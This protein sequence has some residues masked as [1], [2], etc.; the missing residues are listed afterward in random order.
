MNPQNVILAATDSTRARTRATGAALG[1][2]QGC[3]FFGTLSEI[4][5]STG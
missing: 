1:D 3:I 4:C 2:S 5:R